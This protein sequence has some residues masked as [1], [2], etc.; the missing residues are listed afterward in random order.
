M[1]QQPLSDVVYHGAAD[2][3]TVCVIEHGGKRG[4]LFFLHNPDPRKL[5]AVPDTALDEFAAGL[6]AI[7]ADTSLKFC[8]FH[9]TCDFI[10]AGA[11]VTQFFGDVDDAWIREYARKGVRLDVRVKKLWPK[12]RTIAI[13]FGDRFGGSTE[14]PLFAEFGIC[15]DKT[16]IQVTEVHLAILPGWDGLLNILLK[17]GPLNCRYMGQTGNRVPATQ[18]LGMGAAHSVVT[19]PQRPNP[20]AFPEKADYEKALKEYKAECE[21]LLMDEALRLATEEHFMKPKQELVIASEREIED[22]VVRR[23][24]PEPYRDLQREVAKK[25]EALGENPPDDAVKEVNK[26]VS[27]ELSKLGK[28]LAPG[29]V[30][31]VAEFLD[32]FGNLSREELLERFEEIGMWEGMR[33]CDL[34]ATENRHIGIRAILTKN[35]VE[36][37]PVFVV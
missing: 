30:A 14:W 25:M 23:L 35:P 16:A 17:A 32:K 24:N 18:M 34:V 2:H 7:E 9:S 5:Q 22:E 8:I 31:A 36:R 3:V 27:A 1:E 21:K 4:A 13:M 6:D 11:D 33:F 20:K 15:D 12:M 37:V 26:F 28:P 19:T 10:H 29:S